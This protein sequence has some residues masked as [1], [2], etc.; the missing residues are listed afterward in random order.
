MFSN[1]ISNIKNT[2]G[3]FSLFLFLFRDGHLPQL[4]M[5]SPIINTHLTSCLFSA[6][7]SKISQITIKLGTCIMSACLYIRK[8]LVCRTL[9][10]TKS[11]YITTKSTQAFVHPQ[12]DFN[13]QISC[14]EESWTSESLRGGRASLNHWSGKKNLSAVARIYQH[15]TVDDGERKTLL[16]ISCNKLRWRRERCHSVSELWVQELKAEPESRQ[17]KVWVDSIPQLFFLLDLKFQLLN[18]EK[19]LHYLLKW[20]KGNE[21]NH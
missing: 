11:E 18:T 5:E 3:N 19:C 17:E 15:F 4:Q 9:S 20:V 8:K 21:H 7:L 14:Q 16:M 1:L 13:Q 10:Q 12:T 2:K 6:L